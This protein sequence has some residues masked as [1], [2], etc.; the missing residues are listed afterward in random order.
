MENE[1]KPIYNDSDIEKIKITSLDKLDNNYIRIIGNKNLISVVTNGIFTLNINSSTKVEKIINYN[2]VDYIILQNRFREYSLICLNDGVKLI[3]KVNNINYIDDGLFEV[4]QND[5]YCAEKVFDLT[6]ND[7]I[8]F[9]DNMIFKEYK[10]NVL[11][12]QENDREKHNEMVINRNGDII[13]PKIDNSNGGIRIIDKTKFIYNSTLIDFTQKTIIQDADLIMP[14]SDDKLIVLKNRKLFILNNELEI[15]KTYIIGET[16]KPWYTLITSEK[17]I[18]MTFKKKVKIKKYEP[19]IEKNITVIINTETDTVN[20]TVFVPRMSL[21]KFFLINGENNK[22]GLMNKDGEIILEIEYDKIEALYDKDNKYFFVEKNNKFYI[23]NAETRLM[24]QVS[25]T[26]M[27]PFKDGLAVGYTPEPK[28]YQLIDEDL[29][30][31]FNLEHMGHPAFYYKDDILCYHCGNYMKQY[32][33]YTIITKDGEILMPSRQCKVKRNEFD[34]LE[35]NDWQTDERFLFNMNSGQFEQLELNVPI[36]ETATG[37]K[38]DFNRLPIQQ[39]ISNKDTA[40]TENDSGIVKK[41]L[42]PKTEE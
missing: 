3:N 31:V 13:L 30:P 35:I 28:N 14:L 5:R 26:S 36:I 1:L 33:A 32:D 9:P 8:L 42:K 37:K 12:L 6:T 18:M 25:Y 20:K 29:N 40:L 7:Y 17:C 34:L 41:L 10:D 39:F 23:F 19:R 24:I 38:L 27:K 2:G 4:S 21:D 16:K 15:I 11:V 22:K